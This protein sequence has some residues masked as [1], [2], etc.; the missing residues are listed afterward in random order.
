MLTFLMFYI[1]FR[2]STIKESLG[3]ALEKGK[4]NY[5]ACCCVELLTCKMFHASV[6]HGLCEIIAACVQVCVREL[7]AVGISGA[8]AECAKVW[9]AGLGARALDCVTCNFS[10]RL[11]PCASPVPWGPPRGDILQIK[12]RKTRSEHMHKIC[13]RS[14]HRMRHCR[15]RRIID[16][17]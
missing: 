8:A 14:S 2:C 13:P 5:H 4:N 12:A 15:R 6:L 10:S 17:Q 3:T 1:K 7:L 9:H 11:A 16:A